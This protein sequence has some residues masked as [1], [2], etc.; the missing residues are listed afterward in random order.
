MKTGYSK[1]CINPPYGAPICG[2]YEQRFVKGMLDDLFA[3]ALAFD[4]G[5]NKAVVITLDLCT[6]AQSYYDAFKD[7]IVA[8]TDLDRDAVFC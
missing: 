2:Y 5:E 1:V 3:R 8:A 4:D 7:A 6:L